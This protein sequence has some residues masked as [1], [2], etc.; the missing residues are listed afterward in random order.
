MFARP[1]EIDRRSSAAQES[2][3]KLDAALSRAVETSTR[4]VQRR[5]EESVRNHIDGKTP[6]KKG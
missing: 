3:A 1:Q 5:I 4:R 6:A 2:E